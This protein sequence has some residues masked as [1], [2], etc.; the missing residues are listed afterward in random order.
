MA[1]ND[2]Y[3]GHKD[4][5]KVWVIFK[6]TGATIL[7]SYNVSSVTDQGTGHC[8]INYATALAS[9]DYACFGSCDPRSGSTINYSHGAVADSASYGSFYREN[10]NGTAHDAGASVG[11]HFLAI[12]R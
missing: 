11:V 4:N 5:V 12:G 7:D 9:A 6:M 8:R 2:G 10:A 1:Y 3:K